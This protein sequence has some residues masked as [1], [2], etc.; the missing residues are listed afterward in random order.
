MI[1][2]R[3]S[4]L[5]SACL[6]CL[7]AG[8]WLTS[9]PSSPIGPTPAHGRPVLKAIARLAK[10]LLWVSL[11]AEAPPEES[12][13]YAHARLDAFGQPVIDHSRGW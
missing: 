10:G 5:V 7:I 11:L 13:T 8:W 2:L 9:S 12:E 6:A 3:K 4:H 1:T